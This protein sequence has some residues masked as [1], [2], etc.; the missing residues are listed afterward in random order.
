MFSVSTGVMSTGT[1]SIV[2]NMRINA[3]ALESA[4]ISTVQY[5][6]K[7]AERGGVQYTPKD[8]A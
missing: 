1:V 4:M 8:P 5:R 7:A 2:M 6:T 3:N